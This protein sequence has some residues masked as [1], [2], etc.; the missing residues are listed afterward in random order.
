MK[1]RQ[2]KPEGSHEEMSERKR[3]QVC[4]HRQSS[5]RRLGKEGLSV[6]MVMWRTEKGKEEILVFMNESNLG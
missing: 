2:K 5:P 6:S 1:D 3:N 4:E